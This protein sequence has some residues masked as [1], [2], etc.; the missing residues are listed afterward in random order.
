MD[1]TLADVSVDLPGIVSDHALLSCKVSF[2]KIRTSIVK[3][4]WSWKNVDFEAFEQ[5][6]SASRL[7]RDPITLQSTD[8]A[9]IADL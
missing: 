9:V 3:R 2:D 5:D 6:L 1:T 7:C 4:V 8:A